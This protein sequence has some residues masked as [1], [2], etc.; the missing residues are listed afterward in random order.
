MFSYKILET[1]RGP[2]AQI[3]YGTNI[4][5]ECGPWEN[6]TACIEWADGYVTAKNGGIQEPNIS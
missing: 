6:L 2:I 5:D 4:I 3:L 1:E